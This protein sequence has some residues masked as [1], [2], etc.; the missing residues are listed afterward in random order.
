MAPGPQQ[1]HEAWAPNGSR[2]AESAARP[3]ETPGGVPRGA[4]RPARET[5]ANRDPDD[6]WA[7]FCYLGAIFSWLVTPLGIYLLKRKSSL[8]IRQHAAQ[9][10]NLTATASLFALSIAIVGGLLAIDSP[11]AALVLMVPTLVGLWIAVMVY[12]VRAAGSA[13]RGEFYEI[14]RWICVSMLS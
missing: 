12:L 1:H 5:F 3:A 9:A 4:G 14:P 11:G 10:F 8:F 13:G 7:M 2:P 6:Q